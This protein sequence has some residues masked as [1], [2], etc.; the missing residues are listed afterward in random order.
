MVPWVVCIMSKDKIG[1]GLMDVV[2]Q[3][4]IL[5]AKWVVWC[6]E[7]SSPWQVL[8]RNILIST[9]NVGKVKGQFDLFDIIFSPHKFNVSGSFVFMSIWTAWRRVA[10]LVRS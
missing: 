4:K 5:V 10:C 3:G 2:T 9:H 6:L 1:L 7:G 8:M